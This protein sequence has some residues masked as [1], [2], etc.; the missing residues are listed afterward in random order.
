MTFLKAASVKGV[1]ASI[2]ISL[3][4]ILEIALTLMSAPLSKE[5]SKLTSHQNLGL[6]LSTQN[7]SPKLLP[8]QNDQA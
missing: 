1:P 5:K 4:S 8:P 3:I 7:N 6:K 2:A